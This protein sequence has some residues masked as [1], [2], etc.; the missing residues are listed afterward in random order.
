MTEVSIV[1][2]NPNPLIATFRTSRNLLGDDI[3]K[4]IIPR[5]SAV[6]DCCPMAQE[7]FNRGRGINKITF[8]RGEDGNTLISLNQRPNHWDDAHRELA[9]KFIEQFLI[10]PNPAIYLESLKTRFPIVRAFEPEPESVDSHLAQ[11]FRELVTPVMDQHGGSM[12]LLD[13]EWKD[14]NEGK[15]GI[16][17]VVAMSGSCDSCG[18]SSGTTDKAT[19]LV[20][21][22]FEGIKKGNPEEIELQTIFFRGIR[23]KEIPGLVFGL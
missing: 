2:G 11:A 9:Q 16:Y 10:K 20:Q 12:E 23:P 13:F 1:E 22:R 15:T 21:T 4:V 17:A 19:I 6:A 14:E 3:S 18:T 7:I 5:D 8:F